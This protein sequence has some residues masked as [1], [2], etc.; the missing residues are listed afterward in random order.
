VDDKLALIGSA[1]INDRSMLGSRDSEIAVVVEDTKKV[2]SKMNG[3]RYEANAFAHNLRKNVF[4]ITFGFDKDED[5]QDPLSDEMWNTILK[6]V[7]V[8]R[9]NCREILTS[10]ERFL[11]AILIQK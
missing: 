8:G 11:D 10:I 6:R 1:N 4:K 7:T 2:E 5:V 3:A 9:D